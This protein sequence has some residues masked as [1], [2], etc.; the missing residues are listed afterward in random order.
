MLPVCT[1]ALSG[2]SGSGKTTLITRILPELK[3][4]GLS[5]GVL[6]HIHHKLNVDIKGKDTER[7]FRAGADFVLAHDAQQCFARHRN[8]D[9]NLRD[10]ISDFPSALDLIIVEGHKVIDLPGIWLEQKTAKNIT[11]WTGYGNRI[12]V[13]RDDPQY[14]RKVLT[15]I[16]KELEKFH[17]ERP[18]MAGL[19]IGGTSARMGAPKTL[20]KLKG[21]TL[22]ERSFDILS[23]VSG[24]TVLLGSGKLP[25]S[26]DT[27]DRIPDVSG[28]KGPI[29]G[30]LSAFRWSR[31]SA[32]IISSVDMPLM[33]KK[34]WEWLLRQRR[35]GVWAVMPKVQGSKGVETTGAVY[36]PMIFDH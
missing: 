18:L 22:A 19:L 12:V 30:M 29:S 35:P 6:K 9:E 5:V 13:P 17:S 21:K 28:L 20:L 33:D 2:F 25:R 36:E 27:A 8:S 31:E 10:M 15:Y 7:F 4:Q 1:V 32:W 24:K 26:L 34:A 11:A 14:H 16:L 23:A 3:K